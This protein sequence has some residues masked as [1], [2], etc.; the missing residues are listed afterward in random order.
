MKHI[1]R[2]FSLK[3]WV[4]AC[5]VDLGGGAEVKIIF[6]QDMVMLHIKFYAFSAA[7]EV[8]KSDMYPYRKGNK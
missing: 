7:A 1:K 8:T 5:L 2:D 4:R 6:F 3:A